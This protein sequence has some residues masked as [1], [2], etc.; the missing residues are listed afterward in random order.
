[1]IMIPLALKIH[2]N[3]ALCWFMSSDQSSRL[4]IQD[5]RSRSMRFHKSYDKLKIVKTIPM[6]PLEYSLD[7][8]VGKSF[9]QISVSKR[10]RNYLRTKVYA[11]INQG[12]RVPLQHLSWKIPRN[13]KEESLREVE[14]FQT[15]KQH[16]LR[17]LKVSL[18]Q[19][20]MNQRPLHAFWASNL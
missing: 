7:L 15:A 11:S 4:K 3:Q 18:S 8:G 12:S 16:S 17:T 6:V 20:A 9:R 2:R 1:M 13:V 14:A 5:V 19:M 10:G